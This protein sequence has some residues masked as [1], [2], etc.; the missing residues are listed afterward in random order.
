MTIVRPRG[1]RP[2]PCIVCRSSTVEEFLDLGDTTLANRF[3]AADELGAP[4]PVYPLRVGFCHECSHVQLTETVPPSAMFENYLYVSSASDTL[5]E[6]FRELSDLLVDRYRLKPNDLV[7]DIGCNDGSLL[8]G[9]QRHRVRTLGVDPAQ[10]LASFTSEAGIDRYT[11]FFGAATSTRIVERYGAAALVTA[12]NTF[13]HIPDLDDFMA[14]IK[15][16][17]A[18]GGVF[19]AEMHYLVDL[20]EQLAFD[21]VYHEHKSYWALTALTTLVARHGLEICGAERVPIH[22]GQLRVAMRRRGEGDS[23]PELAALLADERRRG[24]DRID[25]YRVFAERVYRLKDEL[26]GA[27]LQLRADGKR[28]V[29][30]GAPAKGNTLLTFLELGPDSLPYIADRSPLKQ[31]RYTPGT[32]IP[33]VP[34]DRLLTDLPDVVLLLAWN[35]VDEIVAQQQP[36]LA[37]GGRLLLP[38]PEVKLIGGRECR[39]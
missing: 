11:G 7:V 36:Y 35:F 8:R 19:V 39:C 10:N 34:P 31:G 21:T 37:T 16:V 23:A 12:T 5:R 28:V 29:G 30:Y 15:T 38:V 18:P 17:L 3:L 1:G 9:F 26:K 24:L 2:E 33:V 4:E 27:L 14:G 20:L 6:H 32:H 22:H 25:T 13:P